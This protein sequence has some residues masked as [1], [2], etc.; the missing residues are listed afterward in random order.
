[1]PRRL[2]SRAVEARILHGQ[3]SVRPKGQE[4]LLVARAEVAACVAVDEDGADGPVADKER[5]HHSVRGDVAEEARGGDPPRVG[6][7][8]CR[9][10]WGLGANRL[11]AEGGVHRDEASKPSARMA[12]G[13]RE[14]QAVALEHGD[15]GA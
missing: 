4:E 9:A 1:M 6:A 3:G 5:G 10:L 13:A 11:A 12:G 2:G 15:S 7:K 8:V 14:A